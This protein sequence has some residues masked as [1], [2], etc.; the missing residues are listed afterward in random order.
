MW[1]RQMRAVLYTLDDWGHVC[2]R[3]RV[4]NP[5]ERSGIEVIQGC[6]WKDGKLLCYP[7]KVEEAD[8]IVIQRDFPKLLDLYEQVVSMARSQRKPVIYEIDDWLLELPPGHPDLERYRPARIPMLGALVDADIVT[9]PSPVLASYVR[10]FNERV[11]VLPNYLDD[12]VWARALSRDAWEKTDGEGRPVIIGYMGGHSHIVDL[13]WI[14]PV[15]I[16]ILRRYG[17][18]V[19]MRFIGFWR[20]HPLGVADGWK[21]VEWMEVGFVDY[22]EFADYFSRQV[23]DIF[24][25]PLVDTPFN[26]AKSHLKFL[27][28]SALSVP[29]VYS[30]VPPYEGVISNGEN[31]FLAGNLREW[32][33]YLELLIEDS[34][35]RFRIGERAGKTVKEKWLLSYHAYR[36]R[37]IYEE[38]LSKVSAGKGKW[39]I[40]VMP[41]IRKLQKWDQE[42]LA[43]VGE[44]QIRLDDFL[45]E[46][47][48]TFE[49]HLTEK[50][51]LLEEIFSSPSWKLV[52]ALGL[53]KE[54]IAPSGSKREKV[55]LLVM[56]TFAR[57]VSAFKKMIRE[58]IVKGNRLQSREAERR[59]RGRPLASLVSEALPITIVVE[60]E[61]GA[62]DPYSVK[63]WLTMQTAQAAEVVVWNRKT[64]KAYLLDSPEKNWLAPTLGHL[65]REIRGKYLGVASLNMLKLP[66]T[67]L[68]MNLAALEG[69]RLIFTL[70]WVGEISKI[71][72]W[73]RSGYIPRVFD[74]PCF[75]VVR[76]EHLCDDLSINLRKVGGSDYPVKIGKIITYHLGRERE[77]YEKAKLLPGLLINTD[78]PG[79][80]KLDGYNILLAPLEEAD[81]KSEWGTSRPLTE[82]LPVYPVL[83]ERPR[84]LVAMP[85]LA[86]GG[87]ERVALEIMYRLKDD[88]CF[89]VITTERHL[90]YLGS[91][92]HLFY[93]VTPYVFTASDW[94]APELRL[95]FLEY[96]INKFRPRTLYI[97]NG[98]GWLYDVL[99]ILKEQ[100]PS[101]RIANQ[102]YDHRIGWINRYDAKM[103]EL[104][105]VHIGCNE[106]ICRAYKKHGVPSERIYLIGNGV[107]T[108]QFDLALYPEN[109]R[110]SIKEQLGLPQRGKVIT[111]MGRL[112]PQKRPL[113][114]VELARRFVDEP[115]ITF[116]MVGDGPLAGTVDAVVRRIRLPNFVR[117]SFLKAAD[118]LAVSDLVVLPSE[119]EGMPMVVLEAQSMGKPVVVTDVGNARE[120]IETTGGGIVIEN[121]GDVSALA[122]GVKKLLQ[123]PPDPVQ[124]R[125]A[126]VANFDVRRIACDYKRALLGEE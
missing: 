101:L 20:Q 125:E 33:E 12:L 53:L 102:V 15:L 9:C 17:E 93:Q 34:S 13:E 116:L 52:T 56:A 120:I 77:R 122:E 58:E 70:N 39:T 5:A 31:G 107:D 112:H 7:E 1:E 79:M 86:V 65:K 123:N 67:C 81:E 6:H 60:E 26:R 24:I 85:F 44:F 8:I 2:P 36:W 55:L 108:T 100:F 88:I 104:I 54:R 22:Q 18:K 90:P 43:S 11:V 19:K 45:G 97:A 42:N 92:T 63:E 4:I 35:L 41:S 114:F 94:I 87:A 30:R 57:A 29:G 27:E 38:V 59:S 21:N 74:E 46:M 119:Y 68:E 89:A 111:F 71:R 105:D 51:L 50:E 84:V 113:D 96:I 62:V 80:L 82:V 95:S 118:V 109:V 121:V 126:V 110:M 61:D 25:A 48:S 49:A 10:E 40:G 28:Y 64:T 73:L 76:K 75:F 37:R 3:L 124:V 69:E 103:A 23:F 14:K 16:D 72:P 83:D 98:S 47:I 91:M 115:S 99:D 117:R 78:E 32:R 66:E 106:K